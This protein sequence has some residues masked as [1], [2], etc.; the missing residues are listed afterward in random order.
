MN[1]WIVIHRFS[2][3]IAH[4]DLIGLPV[5]KDRETGELLRTPE[6]NLI[7]KN[8]T[9]EQVQV[10]DYLAYYCPA[11][12]QVIIGLFKI[13]EGPKNPGYFTSDWDTNIHFRIDPLYP[14]EEENSISYYDLVEKLN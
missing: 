8:S 14:V 3:Y 2:N 11:P 7:P 5:K 13:V 4:K 6:G 12:K 1:Y 10:G 9:I